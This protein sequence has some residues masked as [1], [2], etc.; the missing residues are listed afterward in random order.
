MFSITKQEYEALRSAESFEAFNKAVKPIRFKRA[1]GAGVVAGSVFVAAS[2]GA[3]GVHGVS[4]AILVSLKLHQAQSELSREMQM[5]AQVNRIRT[6]I[7][8]KYGAA[9]DTPIDMAALRPLLRGEQGSPAGR[10]VNPY[11]GEI[12]VAG[13]A[14]APTFEMTE[15]PPD[16]CSVF[17]VM[18]GACPESGAV[19]VRLDDATSVGTVVR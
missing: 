6:A 4:N 10:L 9:N 5:E 8:L 18:P 13:P 12:G 14:D 11:G 3:M 15:L 19:A 2:I 16:G 17:V 1:L 7:A